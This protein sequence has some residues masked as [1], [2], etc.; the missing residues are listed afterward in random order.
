MAK[1][2][3]FRFKGRHV[4]AGFDSSG[5]PKQG[6]VDHRGRI[7]VTSYTRGGE[8]LTPAELGL[9]VI[10]HLDLR[11]VDEVKGN[12]PASRLD[13]VYSETAQQFYLIDPGANTEA[14]DATAVTLS[15]SAVGDSAEDVELL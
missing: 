6:K 4:G 9:R 2:V 5:N 13:A 14:A 3:S 1:T 15:F 10:D 11:V 8:N 7:D 12:D